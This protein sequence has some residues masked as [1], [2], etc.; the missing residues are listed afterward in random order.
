[1]PDTIRKR[2]GHT[3]HPWRGGFATACAPGLLILLPQG[4]R[5][6]PHPTLPSVTAYLD[7]LAALERHELAAL[8]LTLGVILFAVA[9]AIALLRT[10]TRAA[11]R[12]TAR[13]AEINELRE[14]RDRATALLLAEPQ[15]I[16]VWPAGA[17]APEISGDVSIIMRTPLPRRVL[18]FGTWLAPEDAQAMEVA[19]DALRAE[20]KAFALSFATLQQRHVAV[21]GRAIGGRAVLRIKDLT[22]TRSELAALAADHQRVLRDIETVGRLL[23]TLPAPVWA[24]DAAGRLTWVNAAYARAVEARD[25]TEAVARNL[26]MLD[27]AARDGAENRRAAGEF[28]ETRLPVIMAGT[29]RILH[30]IDRPSPGGSAGIGID[31]TEVEAMRAELDRMTEAHRRTLDQLSTAVA[32]YSADQRLAFYNAAFRQLWDLDPA[33]LDS[34]PSDSAVLDRLRAARKLPEQADFRNW[35]NDLHEAYRAMEARAHEWYLPDGRTVRVVTTPNPEGGATYLFDDVTERLKLVRRYEALIGVQGETLEALAEG[36]AVFGSDGRLDLHNPAF[37]RLWRLKA[38]AL[39]G[40]AEQPHIETVLGWCRPLYGNDAFW[41]RLR[42]AVT[43]LESRE[44]VS[45]RLERTDGSVLDCV[46]APL[47]DGATLVTFQDVTDSVNVER[48]LTERADTLQEADRIK[49]AFV[50]H[51]SYELRTPL[52]NII[53]FTNLLL[54]PSIGPTIGPITEK[55]RDYLDSIDKSSSALL[56]II[57]DILDLTTIDAGAMSLDLKAVDIRTAVDAAVLGL[58]D[59]IAEK[60]ILLDVRAAPDIGSFVADERRVRQ[61]L[62]NLLSNA[63][64]FSPAG[65]VVRVAVERHDGAVIFNVTDRGPGIPEAIGS[66]VFDRF[67]SHA[68]GSEHRGAG[69]GLSIVRSFVELHGGTVKLDSAVGRGTTVTC[70]FPLQ[71]AR[72][73]T[74]AE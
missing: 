21:E 65:E 43:T 15:V 4:A 25:G 49:S 20:G 36:V 26:E 64:S 11:E 34:G 28:Y 72:Q 18:A 16:V 30:V 51:V 3:S 50:Q 23:E 58:Q 32:I 31:V 1:M 12:L 14:E 66:R 68:L 35:K 74:A 63:I 53:G 61:V 67:E 9:T 40:T 29:R 2:C 8:A 38:E 13:Q 48:V 19:V 47:P 10:R 41:T 17:D 22:G 7:A 42:G 70:I 52:T 6:E 55:Q 45:A 57:N 71:H 44:P 37:A 5:A 46:T 54:D 62:F 33:F 69:L 24:R 56:A 59:R 73:E 60:A 27:S 39:N